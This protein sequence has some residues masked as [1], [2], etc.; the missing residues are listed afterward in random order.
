[1]SSM[2]DWTKTAPKGRSYLYYFTG[3][4]HALSNV[5]N[6]RVKISRFDKCNDIFELASVS[7]KSSEVG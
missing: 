6:Q 1:M 5:E 3:G 7:M 4:A 2:T